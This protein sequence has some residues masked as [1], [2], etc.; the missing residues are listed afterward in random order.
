MAKPSRKASSSMAGL[1]LSEVIALN[2]KLVEHGRGDKHQLGK[3]LHIAV[4]ELHMPLW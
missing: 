4:H 2:K 3:R 1:T